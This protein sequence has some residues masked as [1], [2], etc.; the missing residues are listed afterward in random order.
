MVTDPSNEGEQNPAYR[1]AHRQP[2]I[3]SLNPNYVPTTDG[4]VSGTLRELAPSKRDGSKRWQ[5]RVHVGRDPDR[6]VR[7]EEGKVIKQRPPTHVSRVFR[8]GKR[9]AVRRS[10]SW[11]PKPT[12]AGE[13]AR[14]P[15]S[16]SS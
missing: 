11:S 5:L 1:P 10:T 12:R 14:V 2:G 7:D 15:R 3:M 8:G 6:T 9:D 13:S 16:A 4:K